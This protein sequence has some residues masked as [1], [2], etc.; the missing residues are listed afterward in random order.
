MTFGCFKKAILKERELENSNQ[1]FLNS[2]WERIILGFAHFFFK[3][4]VSIL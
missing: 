1:C 4:V 2:L 3:P